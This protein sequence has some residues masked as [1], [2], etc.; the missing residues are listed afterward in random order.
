M[1]HK[2]LIIYTICSKSIDYMKFL[3]FWSQNLF[4]VIL[5][6]FSSSI[7]FSVSI[8]LLYFLNIPCRLC[9]P[10]LPNLLP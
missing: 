3:M 9:L 2:N 10:A 4:R 6:Q 8:D 5:W 7:S 1:L